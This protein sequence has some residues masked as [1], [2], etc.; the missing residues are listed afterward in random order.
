MSPSA[1]APPLMLSPLHRAGAFIASLN[2]RVG[3]LRFVA[4]S[5]GLILLSLLWMLMVRDSS[6]GVLHFLQADTGIPRQVIVGLVA[7]IFFMDVSQSLRGITQSY[8]SLFVLSGQS[9]LALITLVYTAIG[10]LSLI[11]A[12]GHVGLFAL[13]FIGIVVIVQSYNPDKTQ[14]QFKRL[15]YPAISALMA[16]LLWGIVTR[17]DTAIIQFIHNR[18]G[19]A[20]FVIIIGLLAWGSGQLRQNHLTPDRMVR[21][22]IGIYLFTFMSVALFGVDSSVSL[23]GVTMNVLVACVTVFYAFIQAQEYPG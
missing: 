9:L 20:L 1:K 18:Y 11:A 4:L 13:C 19:A 5:N 15:M 8:A 22:L 2:L 12:F 3:F 10:K 7:S 23:L 17:P 6:L 14:F 21:R 16:L